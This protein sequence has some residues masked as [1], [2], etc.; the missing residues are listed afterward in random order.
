MTGTLALA[1]KAP[2][3]AAEVPGVSALDRARERLGVHFR[4]HQHIVGR[5]AGDEPIGV[6]SW[7]ERLSVLDLLGRAPL[8]EF[9]GHGLAPRDQRMIP[10]K[11]APDWTPDGQAFPD[12]IMRT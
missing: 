3:R 12:K 4:D 8:G 6:E 2:A 11:P 9:V 1:P 7:R 5:H 10:Q